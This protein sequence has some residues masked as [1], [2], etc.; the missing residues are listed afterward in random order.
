[1]YLMFGFLLSTGRGF[2]ILLDLC[3]RIREKFDLSW[4]MI[5]LVDT[6]LKYSKENQ[7]EAWRQIE[8]GKITFRS[9]RKVR[10]CNN[11]SSVRLSISFL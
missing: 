5:P 4:K 3:H 9:L 6:I 1:M 10:K 8:E 7:E 2:D 11:V